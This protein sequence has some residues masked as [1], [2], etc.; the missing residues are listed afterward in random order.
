MSDKPL[1]SIIIPCYNAEKYIKECIESIILQKFKNFEIL[2]FDDCSNDNTLQILKNMSSLDEQIRVFP[3]TSKMYAG[4][5]RNKGIENAKG[6]WLL[7][8][9]SDDWLEENIL[10]DLEDVISQLDNNIN[11]IE[12]NFNISVD[13]TQ[14]KQAD[15]LNRGKT[16]IKQV[17]DIDI[18]L[19][20][21]NG[22][23]LYRKK[24]IDRYNL[25]NCENNMSGEEIPMHICSYLLAEKI[26]Y[27]NKTGYNWRENLKSTSRS[28]NNTKFLQGVLGMTDFL[29]KEMNRLNIYNENLYHNFCKTI[30]NWHIKEKQDLSTPYLKF[31]IECNKRFANWGLKTNKPLLF[32]IIKLMLKKIILAGKHDKRK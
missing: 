12:Y 30:Y 24:F 6:E 19:A 32:V 22:N 29:K 10:Q 17:K 16:G 25:K 18:M 26:F 14:K 7:F 31:Y 20:T 2:C 21:G 5:L 27:L 28:K 9:D 4:A 23:K 3:S 13:K 1:I 8:C 15:W 11:I